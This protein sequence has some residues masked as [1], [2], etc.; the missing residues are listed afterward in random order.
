MTSGDVL[1]RRDYYVNAVIMALIP[2]KMPHLH[3]GLT[4]QG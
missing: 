2:F 3:W 4:A 1:T